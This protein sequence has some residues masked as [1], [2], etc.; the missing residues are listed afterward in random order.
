MPDNRCFAASDE[1]RFVQEFSYFDDRIVPGRRIYLAESEEIAERNG[2]LDELDIEALAAGDGG[3][4]AVGSH[5]NK[6]KKCEPQASRHGVYHFRPVIDMIRPR[7]P[8]IS[9]RISFD[10]VFAKFPV[11]NEKLNQPIQNNGLNIEGAATFGQKLF[12]GLRA[13]FH[14][15]DDTSAYIVST[16]S[17]AIANGDE[18]AAVEA[19]EL[20]PIRFEQKGVGIRSMEPIDGGLLLLVADAGAEA[21]KRDEC[22]SDSPYLGQGAFLYF[23]DMGSEKAVLVSEIALPKADWKAE[24]VILD[25]AFDQGGNDL[26]VLVFFDGPKSGKPHRYKVSKDLLR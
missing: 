18:A 24:S 15:E 2:K 19:A 3:I 4:F 20:H 12:V 13:P 10:S 16:D 25:P 8:V 17:K 6:R 22:N 11:L 26:H 7:V 5:S 23:W 14:G 9:R 1:A 21:G